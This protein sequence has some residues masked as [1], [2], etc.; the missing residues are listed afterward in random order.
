MNWLSIETGY[1]CNNACLFCYQRDYRTAGCGPVPPDTAELTRK[2]VLGREQG[3]QGVG[4]SGGEP[5]ARSDFVTLVESG[6]GTLD[7]LMA[8]YI[9][10][11][12]NGWPPCESVHQCDDSEICTYDSCVSS[13]CLNTAPDACIPCEDDAPCTAAAVTKACDVTIGICGDLPGV[14]WESED[15][16]QAITYGAPVSSDLTL[17]PYGVAVLRMGQL[18]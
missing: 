17:E 9:D 14:Q 12:E 3:F 18:Q 10:F 7:G 8:R 2:L 11:F 15:V 16:G 6:D 1:R 13:V 5:T 4:F